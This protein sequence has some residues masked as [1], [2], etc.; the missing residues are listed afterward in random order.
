[1]R[2]RR[3]RGGNKQKEGRGHVCPALT[4]AI[5]YL[6]HPAPAGRE[7]LYLRG[8]FISRPD[9]R[10]NDQNQSVTNQTR[11]ADTNRVMSNPLPS[12]NQLKAKDTVTEP[13]I[14]VNMTAATIN[15]M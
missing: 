9:L 15:A 1:M 14:K 7:R 12:R 2:L 11:M 6:A 8:S 4:L 13:A 5:I 3:A 10:A